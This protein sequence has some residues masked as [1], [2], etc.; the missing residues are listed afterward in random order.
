VDAL[1]IAEKRFA[2]GFD[3]GQSLRFVSLCQLPQ[4]NAM[5]QANF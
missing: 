1:R 3:H 2:H 4:N 5:V